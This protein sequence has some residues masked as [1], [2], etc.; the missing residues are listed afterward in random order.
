[1]KTTLSL[2]VG[3]LLLF[4]AAQ[5]GHAQIRDDAASTSYLAL[6]CGASAGKSSHNYTEYAAKL[7]RTIGHLD[8]TQQQRVFGYV[9]RPTGGAGANSSAGAEG[10]PGPI[11]EPQTSTSLA[12]ALLSDPATGSS[13]DSSGQ[14]QSGGNAPLL[15]ITL[16]AEAGGENLLQAALGVEANTPILSTGTQAPATADENADI[17][18]AAAATEDNAARSD[19]FSQI[20]RLPDWAAEILRGILG[21]NEH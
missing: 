21:R 2:A 15:G 13:S 20:D 16:E 1:M 14:T 3:C 10:V 9:P 12:N 19:R 17:A 4:G 5:P 7:A 18:A 11:L 6:R 8:Q